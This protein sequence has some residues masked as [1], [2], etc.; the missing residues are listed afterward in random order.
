MPYGAGDRVAQVVGA[1][2]R[3]N[4]TVPIDT[5]HQQVVGGFRSSPTIIAHVVDERRVFG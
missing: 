1:F 2:Q 5:Q 4:L 3:L